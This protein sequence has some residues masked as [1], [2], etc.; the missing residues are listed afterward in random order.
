[1][2]GHGASQLTGRIGKGSGTPVDGI[3]VGHA[4]APGGTVGGERGVGLGQVGSVG[5]KQ[6]CCRSCAVESFGGRGGR[7]RV[8]AGVW[9]GW[10]VEGRRRRCPCPPLRGRLGLSGRCLAGSP[11]AQPTSERGGT[12]PRLFAIARSNFARYRGVRCQIDSAIA[13]TSAATVSTMRPVISPSS[14]KNP[15]IAMVLSRTRRYIWSSVSCFLMP[16]ESAESSRA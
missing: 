6:A 9:V 12:P 8:P 2:L 14:A 16:L 1:M 7:W 10:R 4:P 15:I 11:T 13:A 5:V 3:A